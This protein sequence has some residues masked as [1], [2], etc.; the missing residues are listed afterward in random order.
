MARLILP[1]RDLA[2][3]TALRS[4]LERDWASNLPSPFLILNL[5][6][7][8]TFL[9]ALIAISVSFLFL[10]SAI[11]DDLIQDGP[12]VPSVLHCVHLE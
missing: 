3:I 10:C 1:M 12:S 11:P 8:L 6:L 2:E 5:F 4:V 9:S 7:P